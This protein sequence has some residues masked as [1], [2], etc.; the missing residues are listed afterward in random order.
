MLY[1]AERLSY[2]TAPQKE[3]PIDQATEIS[4]IITG[5]IRSLKN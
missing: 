2:I 1:L 3:K 5:L 4:K